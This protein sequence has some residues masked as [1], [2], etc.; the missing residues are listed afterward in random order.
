MTERLYYTDP[1][2]IEFEARIVESGIHKDKLFTILDKTAFY[3]T[4]GGQPHD[5]GTLNNVKVID[6]IE[7]D[8]GVIRHITERPVGE[9][10]SKV[11][12]VVDAHRRRYFRQLHT[13]QH[14]L[15][16]AFINLFN[17]E[18]VSVHL[19]EEYG[20]VEL[21]NDAVSFEEN[22]KA[23]QLANEI[24]QLNQSIEI[25]FADELQAAALPLRKKPTRN[26]IIRVIKIGN[27][28]WSACG[29]TH[30]SSTAEVG[31]IKVLGVEKQRGN[32]LVKFL[33]GTKAKDDYDMRFK[34]TDMLTKALTCSVA[35]L[36]G[37]IEKLADDNK[38]MQRQMSLLQLQLLPIKADALA[39]S[40]F[41]T[42][43]VK[44]VCQGIQDVDS[45]QLNQLA[46]EVANRIAG[47]AAL[48][49]DNRICVA[50]SGSSKLD[51]GEIVKLIAAKIN[52]RGGG[53]KQIAQL[54]GVDP[55]KL[56]EFKETL[57]AVIDGM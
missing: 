33:A 54:G 28:D 24:I 46:T 13:A 32:T 57:L 40:A 12:G 49:L 43:K 30:C 6:V 45:K 14:I 9:A 42:N 36:P 20:T 31:S 56:N 35:D 38:Q 17:Y 7:D 21:A 10:Q 29:G 16:R 15:S 23:E 5:I 52:L 34:A 50:V 26:G 8:T 2:L 27:F 55:N 18:T 4:S 47:V 11:H 39:A 22:Q 41:Q 1:G 53:N 3:P 51:A 37:R 19:G 48:L 25:I 44:V